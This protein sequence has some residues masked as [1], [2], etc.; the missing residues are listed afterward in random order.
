MLQSISIKEKV[1]NV[2]AYEYDINNDAKLQFATMLAR[3]P[4]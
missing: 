1:N 4:H 2:Q 3:K